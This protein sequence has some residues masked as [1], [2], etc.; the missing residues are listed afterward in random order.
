MYEKQNCSK[1]KYGS[2]VAAELALLAI[3]TVSRKYKRCKHPIRYYLCENCDK[4]HL[5]STD[6][7]QEEVTLIHEIEFKKLLETK[8]LL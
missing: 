6:A 2:E 7:I 3:K 4:Y 5:T 8:N 1:T